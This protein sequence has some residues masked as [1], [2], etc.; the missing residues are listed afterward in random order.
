[1]DSE[2]SFEDD[3]DEEIDTTLIEKEDWIE[4]IK[5]H[6]RCNGKDGTR[7]DSMLEQD[8]QK[9]KW[10]L[11]LRIATSPSERSLNKAAE[12]NPTERLED[13]EK[14]WK[15]ISTNSSNKNWKKMKNQS[16]A[17][18]KPTKLGSTLP[19]TVEDGLYQK[20]LAQ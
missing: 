12:W 15:M 6:R 19:K 13:R 18:I 3:A 17:T 10:K 8:T 2:V 14:D 20:K 9:I 5:K 11:A 16:R 7:K 4:Y 1:M